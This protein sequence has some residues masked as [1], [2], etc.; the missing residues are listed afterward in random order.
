M[1]IGVR[2]IWLIRSKGSMADRIAGVTL[3]IGARGARLIGERGMW[4]ISEGSI[5]RIGARGHGPDV[6]SR[7]PWLLVFTSS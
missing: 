6:S 1:L 3:L 5:W 2:G 7:I 4:L